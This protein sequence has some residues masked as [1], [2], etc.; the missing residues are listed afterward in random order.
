VA[1]D[2]AAD[3]AVFY[4]TA[5]FATQV[6]FLHVSSGGPTFELPVIFDAPDELA[7]AGILGVLGRKRLCR[8]RAADFALP[9]AAGD[10]VIVG[11]EILTVRSARQSLDAL[12]WFLDLTP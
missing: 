2:F 11:T 6:R 1:I 9:P 4:N 7:A 12:E 3:L 8:A 5:E 10:Q